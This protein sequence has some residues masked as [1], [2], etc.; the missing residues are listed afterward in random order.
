MNRKWENMFSKKA[1]GDEGFA[2]ALVISVVLIMF[3]MLAC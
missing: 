2:M 1:T 3:I